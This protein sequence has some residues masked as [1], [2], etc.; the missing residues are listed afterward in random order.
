[1]PSRSSSDWHSSTP[2]KD[3]NR[4]LIQIA[5]LKR[6]E[7]CVLTAYLSSS[8]PSQLRDSSDIAC[9]QST[10][11]PE[12]RLAG[13]HNWVSNGSMWPRTTAPISHPQTRNSLPT[14]RNGLHSLTAPRLSREPPR[15]HCPNMLCWSQ[16][17]VHQVSLRRCYPGCRQARPPTHPSTAR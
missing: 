12:C 9:K 4:S 7:R 3:R 16:R 8:P 1:M 6:K 10:A 2:R 5:F 13:A 15:V 14:L 17:Y 11:G